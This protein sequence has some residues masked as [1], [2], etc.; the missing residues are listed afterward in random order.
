MVVQHKM[1]ANESRQ[2]V[3]HPATESD[4]N[5][6][7]TNTDNVGG[8]FLKFTDSK[9]AA[10]GCAGELRLYFSLKVIFTQNRKSFAHN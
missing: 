9:P 7:A 10:F 8:C 5:G 4:D 2:S 6:N 1:G 3:S